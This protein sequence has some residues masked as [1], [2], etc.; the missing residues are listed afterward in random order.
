MW[1]G[2]GDAHTQPIAHAAGAHT[3]QTPPFRGEAHCGPGTPDELIAGVDVYLDGLDREGWAELGVDTDPYGSAGLPPPG[4]VERTAS[5]RSTRKLEA[6]CRDTV[7][8][9]S[10]DG[11][12]RHNP[13]GGSTRTTARP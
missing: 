6:A 11:S 8:V 10:R 9:R 1:A 3:S 7:P 4:A 12:V 5:L 13:C 2:E